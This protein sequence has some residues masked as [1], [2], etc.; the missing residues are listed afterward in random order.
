MQREAAVGQLTGT[1]SIWASDWGA[2]RRKLVDQLML[3]VVIFCAGLGVAVLAL[4]PR[5]AVLVASADLDGNGAVDLS[6]LLVVLG[7]FGQTDATTA[8]GDVNGDGVV[9]LSDL[10]FVLG[11]F[12]SECP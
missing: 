8:E 5:N 2:I 11:A 1:R 12:D 3:W 4:P 6:D 9:D 10:L 7:H